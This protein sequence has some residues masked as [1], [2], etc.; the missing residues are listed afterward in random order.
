VDRRERLPGLAGLVRLEV[1]DEVPPDGFIGRCTDFRQGLLDA[2]LTEIALPGGMG[3]ADGIQR[4]RLGNGDQADGGRVP[5]G[6]G[7]RG[8]DA[9]TVKPKAAFR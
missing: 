4:K 9:R 1:A 8:G 7:R 2:V 3:L 6:R 5:A